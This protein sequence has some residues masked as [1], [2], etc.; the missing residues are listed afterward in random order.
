MKKDRGKKVK[1]TF[2]PSGEVREIEGVAAAL[3]GGFFVIYK[4]PDRRLVSGP[5][6]RAEEVAM[7]LLPS[8]DIVLGR[9]QVRRG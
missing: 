2:A 5:A 8:G 6:F 4:R 3:I 7:A 1:V 9:G